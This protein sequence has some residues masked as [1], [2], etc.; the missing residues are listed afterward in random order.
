[1]YDIITAMLLSGIVCRVKAQSVQQHWHT[2]M[3][4]RSIQKKGAGL[5]HFELEKVK[6]VPPSASLTGQLQ[7]DGQWL[8]KNY[9]TSNSKNILT[10][11]YFRLTVT[12]TQR[13]DERRRE[14]SGC[15]QGLTRVPSCGK[16]QHLT[17]IRSA[18]L[19]QPKPGFTEAFSTSTAEKGNFLWRCGGNS[20]TLT[21][22]F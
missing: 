17:P 13:P 19:L 16:A 18:V 8:A 5:Q 12:R 11:K 9:A 20:Q 22:C 6:T 1:M 15:C 10:E 4:H 7:H 21:F 3:W 14:A 2:D